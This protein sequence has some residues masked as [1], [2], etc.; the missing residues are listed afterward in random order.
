MGPEDNAKYESGDLAVSRKD[1]AGA[2]SAKPLSVSK[3]E[4]YLRCP[5]LFY[6]R[7][8]LKV[9]QEQE[10][11]LSASALFRGQ[12]LHRILEKILRL[13]MEGAGIFR[14][15]KFIERVQEEIFA[16]IQTWKTENKDAGTGMFRDPALE[17]N[18][19]S[20]LLE[21]VLQWMS[22][23]RENR[24]KHPDLKTIALEEPVTFGIPLRN[25]N[26]LKSGA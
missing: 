16:E 11:K 24:A 9:E 22:W 10:P 26:S 18:M 4:D 5:F 12:I 3:F 25:G 2:L 20:E 23:E 19:R 15:E 14:D 13:E 8:I 1:L 6:G 21:K 17:E 7:H